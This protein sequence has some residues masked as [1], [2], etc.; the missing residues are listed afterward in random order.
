MDDFQPLAYL[1]WAAPML[2]AKPGLPELR[3]RSHLSQLRQVRK[4]KLHERRFLAK[5]SDCKV[6]TE[7]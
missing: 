1:A 2:C 4:R 6:S 7:I 3:G 5:K